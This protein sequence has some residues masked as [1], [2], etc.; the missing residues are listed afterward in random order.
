MNLKALALPVAL[1]AVGFIGFG[2][3][4]LPSP[5]NEIS[6]NTRNTITQTVTG[7]SPKLKPQ[8]PNAEMEKAI[9]SLSP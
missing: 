2:D 9:E 5:L 3:R 1:L 4:L 6:L 7:A 8:K